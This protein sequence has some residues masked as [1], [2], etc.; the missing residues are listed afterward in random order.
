MT[1]TPNPDASGFLLLTLPDCRLESGGNVWKGVL[2]LECITLAPADTATSSTLPS[3]TPTAERDV[4]LVVRVDN[5]ET[6]IPPTQAI[7]HDRSKGVWTFP[8][9]PTPSTLYLPSVP[10]NSAIREDL[11]TFEVLLS[12]YGVVHEADGDAP[13]GFTEKDRDLKGKLVLVDEADGEVVGSLGEHYV[14][15]EDS[16]LVKPGREKDPVVV[17]LPDEGGPPEITV[18]AV[19]PEE[20]DALLRSAHF[21]SRGIVFATGVIATGM[22]MAS[23][24]F[25]TS[26]TP[27]PTPVVFSER[28]KQNVKRVHNISGTAVHVTSKTTKLIH[29][30]VDHLAKYVSG[31]RPAT[32]A[33]EFPPPLPPRSG[34]SAPTTPIEG[35]GHGGQ[36]G[37]PPPLPARKPRLLTSILMS[38]DLILTTLEQ[39]G[40]HLLTAG[41]QALSG[42]MGHRYGKE[43]G[44]AVQMGGET[45]R[46]VGVVYIDARGVGRRALLKRAGKGMIQAKMGSNK[47][48]VFGADA[49]PPVPRR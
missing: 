11:D 43:M 18:H 34:K 14:V 24:K 45:M 31:S 49:P 48:V 13:A 5:F 19:R 2:A 4:W 3:A 38:T 23:S 37:V 7:L 28:T 10:I 8:G 17:E 21:L 30:A 44:D 42:S 1:A 6:P 35:P 32:P 20:S 39:S 16:S 26:T 33:R 29:G 22:N 46:N 12:Q 41:T 25:I 15:H 36:L 47:E 9:T 27:R 40:K